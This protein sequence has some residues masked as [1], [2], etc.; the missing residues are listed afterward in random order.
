MDIRRNPCPIFRGNSQDALGAEVKRR[1]MVG[2]TQSDRGI[3]QS[4]YTSTIR[5]TK[6]NGTLIW[7]SRFVGELEERCS[8]F[9]DGT[10]DS[11]TNLGMCS[12]PNLED[13]SASSNTLA[14]TIYQSA[15]YEYTLSHRSQSI[16]ILFGI[17]NILN[18][19]TPRSYSSTLNGFDPST[20]EIP[21]SRHVCV[22]FVLS[23]GPFWREALSRS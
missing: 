3:P 10:P 2:R 8:N 18:E 22:K 19:E 21:G 9:M 20:H 17:D 7:R 6:G 14:A 1:E 11:L 16:A 23:Q 13:N 12:S 4:K 15:T 5:W